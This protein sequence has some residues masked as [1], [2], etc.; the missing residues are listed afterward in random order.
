MTRKSVMSAP[1]AVSRYGWFPIKP[2]VGSSA[3]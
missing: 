1:S 3:T 2:A